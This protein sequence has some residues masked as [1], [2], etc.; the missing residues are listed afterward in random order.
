M[1]CEKASHLLYI[2]DCRNSLKCEKSS[3]I[4]VSNH[5]GFYSSATILELNQPKNHAPVS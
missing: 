3:H 2:K 5:Y 1:K 4:N